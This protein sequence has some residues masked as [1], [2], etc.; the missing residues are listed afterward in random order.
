LRI[1][2]GRPYAR[3]PVFVALL[4]ELERYYRLLLADGSAAVTRRW[5][6]ASTFAEGKRVRVRTTSGEYEA[7]T[8]GLETSGALRVRRDDGREQSLVSGEIVEVK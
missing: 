3:V 6:A 8:A 2:G 7:T 1:E 5:A 4:K